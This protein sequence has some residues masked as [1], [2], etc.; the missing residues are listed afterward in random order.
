LQVEK[1]AARFRIGYLAH[2]S[3]ELVPVDCCPIAIPG[4]EAVVEELSRG[5][6]A[7][8]FPD[9]ASELELFSSESGLSLLATV[10]SPAPAP[11]AFGDAWRQ[12]L[13]QFESVCWSVIPSR[14]QAA[15]GNL[16]ERMH[17]TVWGTGAIIYRAGDLHY[18][19]S[20]H[21]F[22]QANDGLLLPMIEAAVGGLSG[23]HAMDLYAG[24]G[25][26]T[27]PLSRHFE[28]VA[29][30]EAHPASAADLA[31]NAGVGGT[32]VQV[33]HKTA[34]KFLAT[35]SRNWDVILVDPPRSGL[36]K[37][38]VEALGRLRAPRVVYV[39]CDPT[40]LARDVASLCGSGYSITSAH[41][42]DQFPQTF[43][44]ETIVHLSRT[45]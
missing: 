3:H 6:L 5:V 39:S 40:T 17:D 14:R 31:T 2:A 25:F 21:S 42:V 34:E 8:L 18:R 20:H 22:F 41:L 23:G 44:I 10:Y 33:H 45:A 16:S 36:A 11:P 26:F 24:V 38:V 7:D 4:L 32:R 43:H 37:P 9:G 1:Q 30:V 29:A 13:P 27:A 35:T 12:R 15:A 28:R 19:V